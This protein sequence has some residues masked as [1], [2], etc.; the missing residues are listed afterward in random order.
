VV[1]APTVVVAAAAAAAAAAVAAV[2]T[3][4]FTLLFMRA[5]QRSGHCSNCAQ[6][7]DPQDIARVNVI[8]TA[9]CQVKPSS[10]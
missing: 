6:W 8:I 7:P 3:L 5:T 2:F 4:G 9:F 1:V 10:L